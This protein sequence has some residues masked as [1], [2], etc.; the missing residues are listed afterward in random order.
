MVNYT[1]FGA[2]DDSAFAPSEATRFPAGGEETGAA[3]DGAGGETTTGATATGA[4][5]AAEVEGTGEAA[6]GAA[7]ATTTLLGS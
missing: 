2:S 3:T 1:S 6:G 5:G 7:G 4:G